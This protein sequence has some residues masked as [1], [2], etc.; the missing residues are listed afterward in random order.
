MI[1]RTILLTMAVRRS[2]GLTSRILILLT[3][4]CT[5]ISM[6][7]PPSIR[8]AT[9]MSSLLD[10]MKQLDVKIGHVQDKV[11]SV[12]NKVDCVQVKVGEMATSVSEVAE[13]VGI[14]DVLQPVLA[15]G[16]SKITE[17][18][19][20]RFRSELLRAYGYSELEISGCS[21]T[22]HCIILN[23]P[24]PTS[25]LV[26]GHIFKNQW[27]RVSQQVLGIDIDDPRNGLPMLKALEDAFDTLR[28][29]ILC[30]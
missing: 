4:Q 5:D 3:S 25:S 19:S 14:R 7:S 20:P 6:L 24:V 18:R 8:R 11:G 13:S 2:L 12:E 16:S 27:A 22:T 28:L 30:K 17:D 9:G 26:A 21:P 29:I 15:F 23:H 1:A 10:A